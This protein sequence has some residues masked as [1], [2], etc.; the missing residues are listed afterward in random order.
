M[1]AEG[2]KPLEDQSPVRSG[3]ASREGEA[4]ADGEHSVV[5]R[6]RRGDARRRAGALWSIPLT[7]VAA[8]LVVAAALPAQAQTPAPAP[9]LASSRP[10]FSP[11][12]GAEL[13]GAGWTPGGK[14]QLSATYSSGAT[15]LDVELVADGNGRITFDS[16][17]PDSAAVTDIL[18]ATAD[19]LAREAAG[20]PAEQRQA[21]TDFQITWFGPFYRPWNTRGPAIGRPGRVRTLEAS[22]YLSRTLTSVL[23]AHYIHLKS[24]RV[25]TVRVG[26]LR[27]AC[28]GLKV[29]FREFNF[30]PVR[31]GTYMVTFDTNPFSDDNIYDSPGYRRV[32]IRRRVT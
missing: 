26:R 11:A 13:T 16:A 4:A 8:Y 7:G 15:A 23:Y 12:T 9:T 27:G 14:V 24:E 18:H 1:M 25:K 10:C 17:V 6:T 5:R 32:K 2:N 22:G 28:R 3:R 30:R 20:A 29:R 19:D 21:S 31:R